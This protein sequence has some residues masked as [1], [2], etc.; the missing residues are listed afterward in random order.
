MRRFILDEAEAAGVLVQ[1]VDER[2]QGCIGRVQ[3]RHASAGDA[4]ASARIARREES[5]RTAA[6]IA[7]TS[8]PSVGE[9]PATA[10]GVPVGLHTMANAGD[11][12]LPGSATTAVNRRGPSSQ[13]GFTRKTRLVP[14]A[15]PNS[16]N[17]GTPT[18]SG[19]QGKASATSRT[20]RAK[21]AGR[22]PPETAGQGRVARR[23]PAGVVPVG[24]WIVS[25]YT[26]SRV[27]SWVTVNQMTAP[28]GCL[29]AALCDACTPHPT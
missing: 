5:A 12:L 15:L 21:G 17:I 4:A 1:Q 14:I 16:A 2:L 20:K 23:W 7:L 6:S 25:P 10:A 27:G 28:V 19:G 18:K 11:F 29:S 9:P 22:P 8:R 13:P 26:C 3:L 24:V